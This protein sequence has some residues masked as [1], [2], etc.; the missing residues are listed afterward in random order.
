MLTFDDKHL[1][2][3]LMITLTIGL[4]STIKNSD[5]YQLMVKKVDKFA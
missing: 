1:S 2:E 3:A 5:S 4:F